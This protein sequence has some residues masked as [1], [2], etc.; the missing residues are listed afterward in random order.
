[1]E[2]VSAKFF[3]PE[4]VSIGDIKYQASS[5]DEGAL[6]RG[7]QALGYVFHTRT[8]EALTISAVSQ[9]III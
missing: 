6:V 9:P 1:M 3:N 7:A 5:P 8:P 2:R 4:G